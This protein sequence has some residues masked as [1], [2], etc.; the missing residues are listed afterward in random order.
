MVKFADDITISIPESKDSTDA[1]INSMKHWAASNRMT[2]EPGLAPLSVKGR[3]KAHVQFWERINAPSF[4]T[5]CIREGYKIPL[6]LTPPTAEFKNNSSAL[7]HSDFVQSA[8]LE[9]VTSGR[10]CRVSKFYLR[11][12]N[13]LS[14]SVQSCGKKRLI[15]DLR[16]VNQYIFKQKVKSTFIADNLAKSGSSDWLLIIHGR[17]KSETA[18]NMYIKDSLDSRLQLFR[19]FPTFGVEEMKLILFFL[20]S[21]FIQL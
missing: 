3:L 20:F 1:T 15:L 17:W 2:L 8:I 21:Y 5:E 14:V 11:V 9:L 6:Y 7:K 13:P 4:I 16:Y 18:Q 19:L 12:I 10:V